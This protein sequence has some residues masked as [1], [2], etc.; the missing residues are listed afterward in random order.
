MGTIGKDEITYGHKGGHS[1][2]FFVWTHLWTRDVFFI[3]TTERTH[4]AYF[5]GLKNGHRCF[6]VLRKTFGH[7]SFKATQLLWNLIYRVPLK[8]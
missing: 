3:R 2:I 7:K 8:D 4:I 6:M 5:F 1:R